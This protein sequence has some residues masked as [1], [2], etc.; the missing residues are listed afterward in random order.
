VTPGEGQ[1]HRYARAAALDREGERVAVLHDVADRAHVGAGRAAVRDD[2]RPAVARH[3]RHARIVGVEHRAAV[4][5][6]G[7]HQRR[8]LGAHAVERAEELG[9]RVRDRR[10]DR[11]GG[12]R[13]RGQRGDL[14]RMR[15]AELENDRLVFG[16]E[17]QERQRKPPLVVEAAA[18]LQH[19]PASAQ[20]ARDELLGRRLAVRPGHRDDRNGEPRS[21]ERRQHAEGARG[22]LDEDERYVGRHVVVE[23]V[24]HQARGAARRG[25][26]EERV[27]V[28]PVT[29]DSEEG[30]A[31]AERAGVDRH[32]ADG[33][34]EVAGD[35]GALARAN[36][37]LH[38]EWRH[39]RS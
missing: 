6:E 28:E 29:A 25:L 23:R 34:A 18:G 4:R 31:D 12:P 17:T 21:V 24:H 30:L 36:D 13:E 16:R 35:Q 19:V 26:G 15:A 37:V 38:G 27:P 39:V 20:H 32:P 8:F 1:L 9:V 5:R 14:A 3:A 33:N 22:V 10:D 11:D 2:G 7:A